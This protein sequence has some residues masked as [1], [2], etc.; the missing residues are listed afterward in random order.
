MRRSCIVGQNKVASNA[1]S[2]Q[3]P[4]RAAL[5]F[6]VARDQLANFLG[7]GLEDPHFIQ[8]RAFGWHSRGTEQALY[9]LLIP[10]HLQNL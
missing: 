7:R 4:A 1:C 2:F 9:E 8:H 5:R 6:A 3:F 10:G